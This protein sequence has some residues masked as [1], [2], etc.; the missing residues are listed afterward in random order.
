MG[1]GTQP[2][3]QSA[4]YHWAHTAA[5]S[6]IYV[7]KWLWHAVRM[8]VRIRFPAWHWHPIGIGAIRGL[9]HETARGGRPRAT[10]WSG[11]SP[12]A[13]A[14]DCV[15]AQPNNA[16]AAGR[17]SGQCR[18]TDPPEHPDRMKEPTSACKCSHFPPSARNGNKMSG[19]TRLGSRP[20]K[21]FQPAVAK[22]RADSHTMGHHHRR[23]ANWEK[24][25]LAQPLGD[26]RRGV[27]WRAACLI[28]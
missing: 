19:C 1:P 25:C 9:W 17:V 16:S 11:D 20:I 12:G 5:K 8:I 21:T 4:C 10:A 23:M 28:A 13:A 26:H 6:N 18:R 7:L 22:K 24:A 2:H 27:R 3:K 15:T 14:R